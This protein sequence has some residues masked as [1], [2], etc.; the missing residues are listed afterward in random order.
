M[1]KKKKFLSNIGF[2]VKKRFSIEVV[3]IKQMRTSDEK[4][5]EKKFSS[6]K[7]LDKKIF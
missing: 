3:F 1:C 7:M 4:V 5:V 6:R 2:W